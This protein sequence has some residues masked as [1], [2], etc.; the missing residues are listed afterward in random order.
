LET[1]PHPLVFFSSYSL[2]I[3]PLIW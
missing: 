3:S 2:M 1:F